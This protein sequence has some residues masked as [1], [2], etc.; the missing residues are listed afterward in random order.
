[1][2]PFALAWQGCKAS[3]F[4][5]FAFSQKLTLALFSFYSFEPAVEK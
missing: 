5:F 3:F 1:M 4:F 2:V